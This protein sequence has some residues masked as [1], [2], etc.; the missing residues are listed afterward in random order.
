MRMNLDLS[1]RI[2][3]VR[4]PQQVS[5]PIHFDLNEIKSHF[6]ESF[7]AIKNQ[8]ITAGKLLQNG[9]HEECQ[10]IWR[11]QIVFLE[12]IL[13][14]FLHE[15]SKY[16]LFRMFKGDWPKSE[17]YFGI[18]VPMLQIEHAYDDLS[19]KE[20]FF[21]FLNQEM[22]KQ[23]FLSAE[24]M[25]DQLNLIGIPFNEVMGKAFPRETIN[26]SA[27]H[28]RMII[29]E[30]FDRRNRIVHQNDR[31]HSSARRTAVTQEL[32][33]TYQQNIASIAQAINEI[34]AAG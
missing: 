21:S 15:I 29:K 16:G 22:S 7:K 3:A 32:V 11:S 27:R 13:D 31:D 18:R 19:T 33:E 20:W 17:K 9:Q 26:E 23:V 25:N 24:S 30:M 1:A 2:E 14:F 6:D 4:E 28:G 5:V 12:G 10:D 8:G 34:A